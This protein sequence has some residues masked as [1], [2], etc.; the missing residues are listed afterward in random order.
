M[1]LA[2]RKLTQLFPLSRFCA[3]S[4]DGRK[5]IAA[6]LGLQWQGYWRNRYTQQ[7]QRDFSALQQ[8]YMLIR[9]MGVL[10]N[11]PPPGTHVGG[12]NEEPVDLPTWDAPGAPAP[13]GP[14]P[15]IHRPAPAMLV[16]PEERARRF[17][18]RLLAERIES[19]RIQLLGGWLQRRREQNMFLSARSIRRFVKT[20]SFETNKLNA[21]RV[22][23]RRIAT[24]YYA[25]EIASILQL[26]Q[27]E[28]NRQSAA[29]FFCRG[30]ADPQNFREI[31]SLFNSRMNRRALRARC[32]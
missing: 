22:L 16:V 13:V 7:F 27:F 19:R 18:D 3:P 6:Q 1:P 32:R 11:D 30:I 10:P 8:E 14:P 31:T 26:F 23:S 21:T 24:P 2:G 28:M 25:R 9:C 15:V 29:L 20:F 12:T 5:R 17:R 4:E